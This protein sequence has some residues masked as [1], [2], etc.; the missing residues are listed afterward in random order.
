M[1]QKIMNV[2]SKEKVS[3]IGTSY[4][5]SHIMLHNESPRRDLKGTPDSVAIA[6]GRIKKI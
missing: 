6:N 3:K 1:T 4:C 2:I 5:I